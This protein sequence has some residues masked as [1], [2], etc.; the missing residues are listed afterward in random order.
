MFIKKRF[1]IVHKFFYIISGCNHWSHICGPARKDIDGRVHTSLVR[2]RSQSINRLTENSRSFCFPLSNNTWVRSIVIRTYTIITDVLKKHGCYAPQ[3][4]LFHGLWSNH[5]D[6]MMLKLS[7]EDK[8]YQHI[9]AKQSEKILPFSSLR[10]GIR[11]FYP[12]CSTLRSV[13]NK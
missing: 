7:I 1:E 6:T 2:R 12:K 4:L 3:N 11:R 8:S 10:E 13:E 5:Y 9:F